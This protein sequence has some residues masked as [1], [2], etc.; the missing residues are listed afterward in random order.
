EAI[1]PADGRTIADV[2]LTYFEAVS[3]AVSCPVFIYQPPGT[4]EDY[5]VTIDV[6][7]RLADLPNVVAIKLSTNDAQY[8]LDMAWAVAGKDFAVIT[9]AETAFLAGLASGTRAV[10]GQGSTVNPQILCAIQTRFEAGD[11]PG[12]RDAQRAANRLVQESVNAVEFMKRYATEHGYPVKP[13]SRSM[14]SNAYG[15]HR[16]AL[17][18]EDYG[19]FKG[20]LESELPAFL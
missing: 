18:D 4:S 20:L 2:T 16:P 10:I 19:Q 8:I 7:R 11:L 1:A 13:F 9:G 6:I 12:A 14:A 15:K 3:Q 5:M 17:S